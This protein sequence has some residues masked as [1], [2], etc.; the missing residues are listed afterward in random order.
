MLANEIICVA[1][2]HLYVDVEP[3]CALTQL[4]VSKSIWYVRC[5]AV[6][7]TRILLYIRSYLQLVWKYW[8]VNQISDVVVIVIVVAVVVAA[9]AAA[10]AAV[11]VIVR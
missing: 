6:T 2:V 1:L 9:A 5:P 11:V 4:G 10:A 8:P 3:F 7:V